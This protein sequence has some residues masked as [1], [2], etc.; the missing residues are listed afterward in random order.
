MLR[1]VYIVLYINQHLN[2]DLL[3]KIYNLIN[4]DLMIYKNKC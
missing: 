2:I 1:L 3:F 4:I